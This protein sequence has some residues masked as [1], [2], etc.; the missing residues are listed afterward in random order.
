MRK[1]IPRTIIALG[2]LQ[3]NKASFSSEF[4]RFS[5]SIS[6]RQSI[7]SLFQRSLTYRRKR[8]ELSYMYEQ[9]EALCACVR[10]FEFI[11][12]WKRVE[13][14][15]GR[16]RKKRKKGGWKGGWREARRR[17]HPAGLVTSARA[18]NWRRNENEKR[19]NGAGGGGREKEKE[20][21]VNTGGEKREQWPAIA[22][23]RA[24]H[25]V[26]CTFSPSPL[27]LR[28]FH[29]P[30]RRFSTAASAHS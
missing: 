23:D 5:R 16:K 14:K 12:R 29:D 13:P 4:S 22:R 17:N 26:G 15:R 30:P 6:L 1:T 2:S 19:K 10:A 21:L 25:R 28:R 18:R 11:Q 7:G 20:D 27:V 3:A 9:E 24:C 8:V